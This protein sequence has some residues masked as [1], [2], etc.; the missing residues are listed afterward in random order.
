MAFLAAIFVHRKSDRHVRSLFSVNELLSLL[1]SFTNFAFL[2]RNLN[3]V[4]CLFIF[5]KQTQTTHL[6]CIYSR[7]E[8]EY[9]GDYVRS[10]KDTSI[11]EDHRA[12]ENMNK[13]RLSMNVFNREFFAL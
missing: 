5:P 4:C 9:L 10:E 1:A 2:E 3:R 11:A 8:L 12:A 13:L 7:A 6:I